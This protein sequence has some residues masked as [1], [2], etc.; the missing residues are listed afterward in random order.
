MCTALIIG[1][2]IGMGIFMLPA[3]LGTVWLECFLGWAVTLFGL[4]DDCFSIRQFG[5]FSAR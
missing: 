2:I 4:R 3:S 5:A 1:N